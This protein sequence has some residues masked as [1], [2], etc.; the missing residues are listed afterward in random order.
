MKRFFILFLFLC[1]ICID[2]SWGQILNKKAFEA[3]K[4]W[5]IGLVGAYMHFQNNITRGAVGLNL[6]IKGF[7]I[8]VMGWPSSHEH[9]VEY[10]SW[11]EGTST[12]F[13]L[14]YQIPIINA[15]RI[16]PVI[17]YAEA[18]TTETDGTDYRTGYSGIENS[19]SFS[20]D[21]SG[22]DA[23]AI[24]CLNSKKINFYLGITNHLIG[25]GVGY[26]F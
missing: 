15:V 20:T 9:D 11:N 18:S 16:I 22:F 4:K 25:G 6:T 12:T 2:S 13:H 8:D 19:Q 17:G 26:Q 24:L 10:K 23:G 1:T 5:S 3:N 7:Y 21:A 14:C